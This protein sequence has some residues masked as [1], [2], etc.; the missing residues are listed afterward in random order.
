MH[1]AAVKKIIDE[2]EN[3]KTILFDW[4]IEAKPGQFVMVWLPDVDE[5]PMSLSHLSGTKGITVEKVGE[6][7][8]AI[9][10]LKPGD[11]I[12]I[13][14][15]FGNGFSKAGSSGD[16]RSS[17]KIL[18]IGGGTGIAPLAP[19][20]EKWAAEGCEI[21]CAIGGNTKSK[22][23]FSERLK[24]TGSSVHVATDDGSDGH[25]GFVTEVAEKLLSEQKFDR[26]ITC[27]PEPMTVIMVQLASRFEVPIQCS[28][29]RYMKCGF[30]I[31]GSCSIGGFRVCKDGPVF[32][33]RLLS[34]LAEF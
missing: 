4:N 14:G 3:T 34:S 7:T 6:A 24:N 20:V 19:T 29:E 13:R 10:K 17:N 21:T 26:I 32:D 12:G 1:I 23:L 25:N 16:S 31:C 5:V 28:L 9:H 11:K 18:A 33:G 15:P 2:C 27:G 22:L 8:A 30:G